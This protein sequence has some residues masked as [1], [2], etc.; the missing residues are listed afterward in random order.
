[1]LGTGL[2]LRVDDRLKL[3]N[4]ISDLRLTDF[5]TPLP[6]SQIFLDE[7]GSQGRGDTAVIALLQRVMDDTHT[8]TGELV[9][10]FWGRPE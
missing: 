3:R 5:P 6:Q 2:W 7:V 9:S 1:M 8:H 10:T 4:L